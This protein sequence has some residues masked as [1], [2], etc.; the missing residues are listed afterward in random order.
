MYD[1][2]TRFMIQD[3]DVNTKAITNVCSEKLDTL[4]PMI[5]TSQSQYNLIMTVLC[6]ITIIK[7]ISCKRFHRA[8]K[9]GLQPPAMLI[10]QLVTTMKIAREQNLQIPGSLQAKVLKFASSDPMNWKRSLSFETCWL[11]DLVTINYQQRSD[12]DSGFS[13]SIY[14]LSINY[15]SLLLDYKS[16]ANWLNQSGFPIECADRFARLHV[17][18]QNFSGLNQTFWSDLSLSFL[19]AS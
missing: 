6:I 18:F 8:V 1:Q 5:E 15:C 19:Y 14:L 12:S 4:K 16:V 3:S 9:D 7:I 17:M 11:V 2:V 13:I 10:N